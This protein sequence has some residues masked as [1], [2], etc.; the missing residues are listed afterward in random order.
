M[1]KE[2]HQVI[3]CSREELDEDLSD[4]ADTRLFLIRNRQVYQS[5]E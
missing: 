3:I 2:I 5:R 1:L 4:Y